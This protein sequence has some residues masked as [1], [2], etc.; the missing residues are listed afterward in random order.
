MAFTARNASKA[1]AAQLANVYYHAYSLT[2]SWSTIF[3]IIDVQ[4]YLEVQ[5]D[6]CLQYFDSSHDLV[7]VAE[8]EESNVYGGTFGRVLKVEKPDLAKPAPLIGKNEAVVPLM[9]HTDFIEGLLRKYRKIFVV[10]HFAVSPDK[11]GAGFGKPSMDCVIDEAKLLGTNIAL[12]GT[13]EAV[14]FYK[15]FGFVEITRPETLGGVKLF[16]IADMPCLLLR[17]QF[18]ELLV[19]TN[20]MLL[21]LFPAST[22]SAVERPS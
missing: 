14:G 3:P 7:V 19:K 5:T 6:L 8:D 1:D 9:D 17:L 12:A 10:H 2:E 21:E 20:R 16:T 18:N 4:K 13:E 11:Q 22:G 15:K